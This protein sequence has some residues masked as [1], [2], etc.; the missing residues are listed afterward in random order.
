MNRSAMT[1]FITKYYAAH[2]SVL[3]RHVP[4]SV[5]ST[6]RH[7]PHY[8][9]LATW[10]FAKLGTQYFSAL[11][12]II[13]SALPL[14]SLLS[15]FRLCFNL[16][17]F[18]C[19]LYVFFLRF[20]CLFGDSYVFSYDF[21]MI[22]MF[23]SEIHMFFWRFI[24]FFIWLFWWFILYCEIHM[25]FSE[26]Y[27][28]CFFQRFIYGKIYTAQ[29]WFSHWVMLHIL[30]SPWCSVT[31]C[32]VTLLKW[33]MCGNKLLSAGKCWAGCCS[34]C[35]VLHAL[36]LMLLWIITFPQIAGGSLSLLPML[37]TMLPFCSC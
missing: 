2:Y 3:I 19:D 6:F 24:F 36:P 10:Y 18:L 28:I 13:L 9:A 21:L 14:Y 29:E 4:N 26:I 8:P 5:H 17:I 30:L 33:M 15:T 12:I 32:F 31:I 7:Y 11:I 20:I 22:Y 35:L 34:C 23:Y 25:Y 1:V 37:S 16:Y 27:D